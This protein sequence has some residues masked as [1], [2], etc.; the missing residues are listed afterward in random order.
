MLACNC[1]P[2]ILPLRP[3]RRLKHVHETRRREPEEDNL[4]LEHGGIDQRLLAAHELLLRLE[5]VARPRRTCTAAR[6]RPA[7]AHDS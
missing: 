2:G 6:L 4:V 3:E 1:T 5:D 7:P